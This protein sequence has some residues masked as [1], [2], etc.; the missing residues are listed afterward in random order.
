MRQARAKPAKKA[1]KK[2]IAKKPAK[3]VSEKEQLNSL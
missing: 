3:P 2:T 1:V